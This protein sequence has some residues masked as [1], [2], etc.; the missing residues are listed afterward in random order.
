MN[1]L[2]TKFVAINY[3][4]KKKKNY[5]RTK[6]LQRHSF[7]YHFKVKCNIIFHKIMHKYVT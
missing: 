1:F 3:V 7:I 5:A 6:Y 4:L 2:K